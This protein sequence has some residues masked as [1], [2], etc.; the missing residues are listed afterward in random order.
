MKLKY[1]FYRNFII[2]HKFYRFQGYF[3]LN[4]I[5]MQVAKYFD[6]H[7]LDILFIEQISLQCDMTKLNMG[8]K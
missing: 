4:L 5:P 1:I 2:G 3:Q 8:H 6:G 7:F